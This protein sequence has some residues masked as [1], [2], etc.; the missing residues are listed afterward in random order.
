MRT[1]PPPPQYFSAP[2]LQYAYNVQPVN[3][4]ANKKQVKIAIII[5]FSYPNVLADLATYW[6]HPVNFGPNSTPPTVRVHT[7]PGAVFDDGWA[8]EE[9]LD[10]QMVAAMNPNAAIWVVEAASDSN[11]DLMAAVQYAKHTLQA[12]VISM[13]WG[14]DDTS[15]NL[16]CNGTFASSSYPVCF[17]ASSGDYN[18][19]SW[20]AVLPN[21]LAVGGTTLFM[22]STVRQ[23]T[24]WDGA[25]C[26][27]AATVPQPNYQSKMQGIAHTTRVIPDLSLA[28]NPNNS[29]YVVY[30]GAWSGTGGTSVSCPLMAGMLSLAVQA[31]FNAGKPGLTTL[32]TPTQTTKVAANY[33]PPAN[34]L[35]S[36]LYNVIYPTKSA[37]DLLDVRVGTDGG[38]SQASASVLTTFAATTGYDVPTG[39]GAPNCARLCQEL[40]NVV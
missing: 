20:P 24:T 1:V 36:Y 9:C 3:A 14:A 19:V 27:Y 6:K 22:T 16:S 25:G 21:V 33:A 12:D 37:V 10:V 30:Q 28:A 39:L 34:H 17:C 31:R 13:S 26:G 5:A 23:E 7:M 29:V 2:Q 40:L 35:Q 32:Y 15:D 18:T 8:Q 38:S 11:D 4:L